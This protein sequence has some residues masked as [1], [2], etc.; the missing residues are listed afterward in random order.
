MNYSRQH[1]LFRQWWRHYQGILAKGGL[2][3]ALEAWPALLTQIAAR[4]CFL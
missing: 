2:P 1:E 4:L 3:L